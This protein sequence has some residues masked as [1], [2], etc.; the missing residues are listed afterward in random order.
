[1]R[2]IANLLLMVTAIAC[3]CSVVS[4]EEKRDS[5]GDSGKAVKLFNGECLAGWD[6]FTVDPEVKMQDVWS[7]QDGV[8][9]CKGQPLG[10]LFTKKEYENFKL[11][12][13]WRWPPGKKPGN[14]GVLL[15]ISG[16]AVG[17]L[18]KCVEA[19]LMHRSAGDIWG[20]H[21]FKLKGPA[22]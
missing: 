7:V 9:V 22:L 6:C 21:G 4:A 11:V 18:P 2:R 15:R 8:L 20:F 5:A 3:L 19:Q 14:S 13:E 16:D 12:V 17:F 10:Y 1:M